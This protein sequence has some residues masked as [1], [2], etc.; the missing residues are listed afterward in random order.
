MRAP[1]SF[2]PLVPAECCFATIA[3]QQADAKPL[4]SAEI[5]EIVDDLS[6]R[7]NVSVLGVDIE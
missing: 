1:A 4:S 3:R 6:L 7:N 5:L 2:S